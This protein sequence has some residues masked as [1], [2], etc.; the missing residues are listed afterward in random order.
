MAVSR[1]VIRRVLAVETEEVGPF[2]LSDFCLL[3]TLPG[4]RGSRPPFHRIDEPTQL[5]SFLDVRSLPCLKRRRERQPLSFPCL[6]VTHEWTLQGFPDHPHR[7]QAT[8]TYML[9][10]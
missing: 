3:T 8:V 10:G 7:G 4:C 2:Y 9:E 6:A 1:V 5:D